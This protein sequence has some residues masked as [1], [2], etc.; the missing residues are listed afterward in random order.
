MSTDAKYERDWRKANRII[1]R[2]AAVISKAIT[3]MIV[4]LPECA[5]PQMAVE[6]VIRELARSAGQS[7]AWLLQLIMEDSD[8]RESYYSEVAKRP[9]TAKPRALT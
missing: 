6:C 3:K 2:T 1:D 5:A 7:E 4:D 8:I 9:A